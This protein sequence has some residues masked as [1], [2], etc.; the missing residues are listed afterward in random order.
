ML[1]SVE[2]LEFIKGLTHRPP[3]KPG[4]GFEIEA[5]PQGN[6]TQPMSHTEPRQAT[7]GVDR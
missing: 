3:F 7:D 5:C 1:R 4:A 2:E 6:V